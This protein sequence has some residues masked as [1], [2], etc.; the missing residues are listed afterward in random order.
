M[1]CVPAVRRRCRCS[2]SAQCHHCFDKPPHCWQA[3]HDAAHVSAPHIYAGRP[4][5]RAAIPARGCRGVFRAGRSSQTVTKS[6]SW[7]L[8]ESLRASRANRGHLQGE[9]LVKRSTK[10]CY[11]KKRGA[12]ID[13]CK[14]GNDDTTEQ[15]EQW[16]KTKDRYYAHAP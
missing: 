11:G 8:S 3:L 6:K 10:P 12:V 16:A 7:T 15:K 5:S 2:R 1:G 14:R 4:G 13:M 9:G